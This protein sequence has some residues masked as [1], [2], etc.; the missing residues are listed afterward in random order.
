[1]CNSPAKVKAPVFLLILQLKL[2]AHTYKNTDECLTIVPTP[3]SHSCLETVSRVPHN[4]ANR[5][6]FSL[7]IYQQPQGSVLSFMWCFNADSNMSV[8]LDCYPDAVFP[9]HTS[10]ATCLNPQH[11]S[12]KKLLTAHS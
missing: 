3:A 4:P 6:S 12:L 10:K 7:R 8:V 5:E 2:C 9:L 11:L 1:M